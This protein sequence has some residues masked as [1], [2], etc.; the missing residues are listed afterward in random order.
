[1]IAYA[2]LPSLE[3]RKFKLDREI[4]VISFASDL[5]GVSNHR[6]KAV[7]ASNQTLQD[8][9]PDVDAAMKIFVVAVSNIFYHIDKDQPVSL[10]GDGIV[11]YPPADPQ[12]MLA[13]HVAIVESDRKARD[14]GA[15]LKKIFSNDEVKTGMKQIAILVASTG[16]VPAQ[17]VTGLMGVATTIL[18]E[19]LVNNGDDILFSHNHSGLDIS[20]YGGSKE[21]KDYTIQNKK[22][23]AT[24]RIYSQL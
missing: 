24:L 1:M 8:L 6:P 11:L 3:P 9:T 13:L 21:G 18:G 20:A 23:K 7:G 2:C 15:L 19:A 10:S 16:N 14:F 22:V 5:R 17:L 12:G 4:Y